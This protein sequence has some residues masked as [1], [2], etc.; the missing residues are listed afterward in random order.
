MSS[1]TRVLVLAAVTTTAA[2]L[3]TVPVSASGGWER[4]AIDFDGDG[5]GDISMAFSYAKRDDKPGGGTPIL[6]GTL[7]RM[8]TGRSPVLMKP[9]HSRF[10]RGFGDVNGDGFT[11]LFTSAKGTE[12]W[13][14]G[15]PGG[16]VSSTKVAIP[17]S[18]GRCDGSTSLR[19]AFDLNNDGYD[20]LACLQ[21]IT[22]DLSIFFGSPAGP[23]A[24]PAKASV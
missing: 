21:W 23:G 8:G 20:D 22:D 7:L 11:D 9:N 19:S 18:V 4:D 2:A 3:T 14:P 5:R 13:I 10:P 17:D 12:V 6:T 1:L 24:P 16:L 15:G